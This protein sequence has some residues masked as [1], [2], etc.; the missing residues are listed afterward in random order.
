MDDSGGCI[1]EAESLWRAIDLSSGKTA[2]PILRRTHREP[3]TFHPDHDGEGSPAVL[4]LG[5]VASLPDEDHDPFKSD[6]TAY[7]SAGALLL[8]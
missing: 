8:D 7:G 1:T 2:C 6:C 3:T 5:D 4:R